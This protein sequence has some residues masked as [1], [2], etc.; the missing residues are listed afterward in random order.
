MGKGY[1]HAREPLG[2][3]FFDLQFMN[4]IAECEKKADRQR[5]E[6]LVPNGL[7][8]RFEIRIVQRLDNFSLG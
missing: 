5:F 7:G 8:Y 2:K 1:G 6:S 3:K 4:R